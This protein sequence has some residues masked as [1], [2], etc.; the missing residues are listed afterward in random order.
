[1]RRARG[2]NRPITLQSTA[3]LAA[4]MIQVRR[5][6]GLPALELHVDGEPLLLLSEPAAAALV[7]A[8]LEGLAAI[9]REVEP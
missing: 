4:A 6:R 5:N 8:L 2:V 1:M 9:A 3:G 7:A